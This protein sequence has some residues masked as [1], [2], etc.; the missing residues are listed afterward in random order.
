MKSAA[1]PK[2]S[3]LFDSP[4]LSCPCWVL[5]SLAICLLLSPLMLAGEEDYR[6]ILRRCS[7]VMATDTM[8]YI[9][10]VGMEKGK[11]IAR[12]SQ[13][14]NPDGTVQR[15]EEMAHNG[16]LPPSRDQLGPREISRKTYYDQAGRTLV[17]LMGRDGWGIRTRAAIPSL[18]VID[19]AEVSGEKC[20][21]DG[22]SC[23]KITQR[24]QAGDGTYT[25]EFIVQRTRCVLLSERQF[26]STGRLLFASRNREFNFTP[27]LPQ[28]L[29]QIPGDIKMEYAETSQEESELLKKVV[30]EQ[31]DIL[32]TLAK[33]DYSRNPRRL[34]NRVRRWVY[35]ARVAPLE[36]TAGVVRVLGLV[37]AVV[38][39]GLAAYVKLRKGK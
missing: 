32:V 10:Q 8:S 3:R 7:R 28:D 24:Y 27:A 35:Q 15:V 25:D 33:E 17:T 11:T 6:A 21:F 26:D 18:K 12:V 16:V 29:F 1:T 36:A 13:R 14:R 19:G 39:V 9:R 31:T 20:Q 4:K 37:A 23:W 2:R 34:K 22:A 38:C 5:P 30:A